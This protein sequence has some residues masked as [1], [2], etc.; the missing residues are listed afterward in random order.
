MNWAVLSVLT[1]NNSHAFR[2]QAYA[3]QG[4][5]RALSFS[6]VQWELSRTGLGARVRSS[7]C[8]SSSSVRNKC[9]YLQGPQE[10]HGCVSKWKFTTKYVLLGN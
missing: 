10:Q 7:V 1:F 6:R 9:T 3:L 5:G 8:L 4:P 2:E